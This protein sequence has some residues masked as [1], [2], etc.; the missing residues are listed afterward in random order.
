[1]LSFPLLLT[2][3]PGPFPFFL[4][5]RTLFGFRLFFFFLS[6]RQETFFFSLRGGFLT[7]R[8]RVDVF[9]PFFFFP[10]SPNRRCRG[11][12]FPF[13]SR[14]KKIPHDLHLGFLR[15][16]LWNGR[17]ASPPS[18]A[19]SLSHLSFLFLET[20]T[21]LFLICYFFLVCFLFGRINAVSF[22]GFSPTYFKRAIP[23]FSPRGMARPFTLPKKQLVPPSRKIE[24]AFFFPPAFR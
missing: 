12:T 15:P 14:G 22:C 4:F 16:I 10:R 17:S 3:R 6:S 2:P 13:F 24:R 11:Y 8:N 9:C 18:P 23:F 21:L 1:L 19:P 20:R 7:T 5:R